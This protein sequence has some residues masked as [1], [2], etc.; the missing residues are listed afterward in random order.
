MYFTIFEPSFLN[1]LILLVNG[2]SSGVPN[3]FL[4]YIKVKGCKKL[5]IVKRISESKFTLEKV[6]NQTLFAELH[7]THLQYLFFLL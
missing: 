1:D 6:L 7:V 5:H 3:P 4:L 2:C